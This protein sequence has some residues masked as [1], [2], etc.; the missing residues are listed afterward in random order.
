MLVYNKFYNKTLYFA[1]MVA[2]HDTFV[3]IVEAHEAI[4]RYVLDDGESYQVYKSDS[5]RYILILRG[6]ELFLRNSSVVY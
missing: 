5:K 1:T 6:Q 3:S 2:L 4:N